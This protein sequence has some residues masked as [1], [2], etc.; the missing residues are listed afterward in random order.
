LRPTVIDL[1]IL[2]HVLLGITR[3]QTALAK[4]FGWTGPVFAKME[5]SGVWR[6]IPF[7][8]TSYVLD[9]YEKHGLPLGLRD[10][11]SIRTGTDQGSFIELDGLQDDDIEKHRIL[12]A[13]KLFVII[14]LALG[15]PPIAD[16]DGDGSDFSDSVADFLKAG[17]RALE[18]QKKRTQRG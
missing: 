15:I 9:E 10:K 1:N 5:I 6:T 14:A 3:I 2:L 4:E 18:A 17:E 8:D 16:P 12:M 7:V 11:I 13:T